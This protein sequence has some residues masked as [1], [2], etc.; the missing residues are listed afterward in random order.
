MA[1]PRWHSKGPSPP[2]AII[3]PLTGEVITRPQFSTQWPRHNHVPMR[4]SALRE[5]AA[6]EV[7]QRTPR[8]EEEF[9]EEEDYEE[10]YGSDGS[11]KRQLAF[12]SALHW[13]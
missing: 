9:E 6:L 2:R 5:R 3:N 10:G 4:P 1:S 7:A 11:T 13:L 8:F 12:E